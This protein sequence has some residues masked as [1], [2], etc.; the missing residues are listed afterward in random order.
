MEMMELS[1]QGGGFEFC[2]EKQM[3]C[4]FRSGE[5]VSGC[6]EEQNHSR[7]DFPRLDL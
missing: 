7:C 1:V 6:K 3:S 4:R 2:L 5:D